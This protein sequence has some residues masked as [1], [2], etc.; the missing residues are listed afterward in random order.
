MN[1]LAARMVT[2]GYW[3]V[4]LRDRVAQRVT[5]DAADGDGFRF[6]KVRADSAQQAI[7]RARIERNCR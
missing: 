2:V 7:D 3:M 5:E 4:D 6:F 1:T